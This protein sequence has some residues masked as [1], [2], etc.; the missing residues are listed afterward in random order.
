MANVTVQLPMK[1]SVVASVTIQIEVKTV[2][3]PN[4]KVQLKTIWE[5]DND[6][7]HLKMII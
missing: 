1:F 5:R 7:V 2:G 3:M 4:V 6:T